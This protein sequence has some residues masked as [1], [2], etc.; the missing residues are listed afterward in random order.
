MYKTAQNTSPGI[1]SVKGN[2]AKRL[3]C[4]EEKGGEAWEDRKGEAKARSF[5]MNRLRLLVRG[6]YI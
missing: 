6:E 1:G 2:I 5:K 3:E 4:D